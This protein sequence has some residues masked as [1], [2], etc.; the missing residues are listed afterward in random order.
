MKTL[1]KLSW[2]LPAIAML[3]LTACGGA[4]PA[5]SPTVDTAPIFTQL[6]STAMA[7]QTQTVQAA[8]TSTDTP[9]AS[10]T[11][12]ATNTPLLTNT[13][14]ANTPLPGTPSATPA[15][16]KTALP[17]SQAACD[18]MAYVSD[19]TI[20]DGYTAAPGEVMDKT[21]RI[22]NLGPC[23]WNQDYVLVFGWGGDGTNWN[24]TKAVHIGKLV[25]PGEEYEITISLTAPKT[26]GSY[27]AFFRLQ[28]D[29]GYNFGASLSILIKV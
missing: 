12:Q 9:Q 5:A 8:P 2:L 28:N 10:P 26:S 3:A 27:G 17:T 14:G 23:T 25:K 1:A 15:A 21:W 7:L 24:G 29:K 18:N 6:A 19:V 22:K 4:G 11:P 20:P 13:P 16:L